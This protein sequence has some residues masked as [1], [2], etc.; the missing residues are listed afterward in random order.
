MSC[1]GWKSC[2]YAPVRTSSMTVGSR[3][4]NTALGTFF[5]EPVSLKN[6][7]NESLPVPCKSSL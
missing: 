2:L 6:V 4:T 1:S 5:P 3:S 7:L